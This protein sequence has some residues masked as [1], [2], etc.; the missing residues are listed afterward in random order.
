MIDTLL[1]T[2]ILLILVTVAAQLLRRRSA[3]LRHLLWSFAIMGLVMIPI[4]TRIAPQ[5]RVLPAAALVGDEGR[6]S[7]ALP[8]GGERR[9][10]S[11]MPVE[12]TAPADAGSASVA[13][14]ATRPWSATTVWSAI[15]ALWL[16]GALIL[17]ARLVV[18][19]VTVQRIAGRAS[20]VTDENWRAVTDR[21]IRALDVRVLVDVRSSEEVSMP[22]ACG[23]TRPI[24]VL[25]ANADSWN[26]QQKEAVIL[27]E[28]AHISRGDLA[29]NMVSHVVRAVYWLNPMVWVAAYRLRVEGERACDD[30]VLRGGARPSDYA[31]HLLSIVRAVGGSA[32]PNVALA[33]ARRSDFEGR[34]LAI[35]EPGISRARLTRVR[36]AGLA[37]LFLATVTPLAAMTVNDRIASNSNDVVGTATQETSSEKQAPTNKEP[38]PQPSATI[39]A[40]GGALSDASPAVRLAAVNSLGGLQD[41]AAIAALARALKEDTDARVREAAAWALGEIDDSR[42]VPHLLEALKSEKVSKVR[43]KIVEALGEIKDPSA[44][45]GILNVLKDPSAEVRRAAVDALG[46]ME[47]ANSMQSLMGM[48]RDDDIEVRRKISQS[49]GSF[50]NVAALDAIVAMTR[51]ADAE[52]RA[53]AVESLGHIEDRRIVDPLVASL[54]DSNADV[55]SHAAD[56]LGSIDGLTTAPRALIDALGDANRDVRQNAAGA[57]GN[58]G[59]EAA[60]PALKRLVSDNDVDTRRKAVEALKDIG[61]AEAIQALMGLLKDP[62]PEIRKTAAEALGKRHRGDDGSPMAMVAP[63]MPRAPSVPSQPRL[64]GVPRPQ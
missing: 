50:E 31:D 14:S 39:A 18:G 53:N 38:L 55:R 64:A 13:S 49:L 20:E 6:A 46:E 16:A 41:P 29:M 47:D 54:K 33:M 19:L 9:A 58:I 17:L 25:P 8:V 40:L 1:K 56:A 22:F 59:D 44:V 51:D 4:L 15:A 61:G 36:A 2:T 23:L 3:A 10:E 5:W 57:L 62:D 26:A 63:T 43:E 11:S 28:L 45:A 7:R 37:A 60:V 12:S 35:L 48:I 52:V 32:V 42:A 27:H 34:L 30:A 21:S 24:I